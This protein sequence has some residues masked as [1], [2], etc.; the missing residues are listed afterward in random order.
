MVSIQTHTHTE[1]HTNTLTQMC[2]HTQGLLPEKQT[3]CVQG[4]DR[5]DGKV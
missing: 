4:Q 1:A 5:V 3:D 2:S